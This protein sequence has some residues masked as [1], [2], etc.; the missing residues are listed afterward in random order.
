MRLIHE[1]KEDDFVQLCEIMTAK[2]NAES[3]FLSNVVFSDEAMFQLNG[4]VNIIYS[5][6]SLILH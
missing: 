4:T 2:I 3:D 5:Y 1:I 6:F